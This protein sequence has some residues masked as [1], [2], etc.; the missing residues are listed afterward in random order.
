[1]ALTFFIL[2]RRG[3]SGGESRCVILSDLALF[4]V[5]IKNVL[6]FSNATMIGSYVCSF[7][8]S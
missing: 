2:F 7:V 6:I 8:R 5:T 3:G 1:M 4:V